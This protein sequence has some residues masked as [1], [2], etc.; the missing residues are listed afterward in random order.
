MFDIQI[1]KPRKSRRQKNDTNDEHRQ[2]IAKYEISLSHD[3]EI[4]SKDNSMTQV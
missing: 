2:R 1:I 3:V 4:K